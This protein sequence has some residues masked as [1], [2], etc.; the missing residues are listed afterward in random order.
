MSRALLLAL[1]L[2]AAAGSLSGCRWIAGYDSASGV[3]ADAMVP[4]PSCT[5]ARADFNRSGQVNG[6]DFLELQTCINKTTPECLELADVDENGVVDGED[7]AC[8]KQFSGCDASPCATAALPLDD[9]AQDMVICQDTGG[10]PG[11]SQCAAEAR[12]CNVAAGWRLCSATEF[13]RHDGLTKTISVQAWIG[14]CV[15]DSSGGPTAPTDTPCSC[16]NRSSPLDTTLS[17]DCTNLKGV[18]AKFIAPQGVTTSE[19][20]AVLGSVTSQD[21]GFW[22]VAPATSEAITAAACCR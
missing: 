4:R 6:G 21:Q 7:L 18:P 11:A 3:S 9:L 8:W 16:T 19:T 20:C 14:G 10:G 1:V 5:C 17:F 2:A 15:L 22:G 13:K 12:Y